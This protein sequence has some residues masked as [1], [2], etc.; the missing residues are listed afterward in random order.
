MEVLAGASD[1]NELLTLRGFLRR[2]ELLSLSPTIDESA[3]TIRRTGRLRLP[4]AII[5]A[6]A[7]EQKTLLVTRNIRDFSPDHPEIRVPYKLQNPL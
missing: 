6:T 7:K 5:W 4:D 2:F 3:V 1:E